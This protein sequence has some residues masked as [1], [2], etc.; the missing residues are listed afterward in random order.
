VRWP[1]ELRHPL[2][3]LAALTYAVLFLNRRYFH[4]PLPAVINAH[5]SDALA[6]PVILALALAFFRR[7]YF[8]QLAFTLPLSWVI[9]AWLVLSLWFEML[10]P[11]LQPDKAT[12]DPLDVV[13][14]ALGGLVFWH[15]L[16][17]PARS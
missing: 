2:V 10:L 5:L 9:S 13:A 15:W 3:V 1:A 16:N 4:W 6:L 17:R 12:G 11:A 14:Y 8:Q 7:L